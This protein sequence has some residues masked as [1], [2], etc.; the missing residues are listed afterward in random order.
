MSGLGIFI[1]VVVLL[2][3]VMIHEVA[4]A[5]AA[6]KRG[7]DTAK[8]AGRI[9][10][11][12]LP[13]IDLFGSIILPAVMLLFHSPLLFGWAKPVPVN[14][15]KLKNPH[16]DSA[17]VSAAGPLSNALL[18]VSAA[19]IIR[20]V[21]AF[22]L[23]QQGLAGSLSILLSFVVMV[24]IVLLV[25]NLLPIPPL[26]GS[27]IF[28]YFLPRELAYKYLNLNP[29]ICFAILILVLSSDFLWETIAPVLNTFMSVIIGK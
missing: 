26:D 14:Y 12:P 2:F 5:Y 27:K 1:Y 8:L 6:Y 7:D 21:N 19:F 15:A 4:H 18:A 3:S 16:F 25:L 23:S 22:S 10:L 11:N 20:A 28:A 29:F 24:N 17:L 9:T 13:H